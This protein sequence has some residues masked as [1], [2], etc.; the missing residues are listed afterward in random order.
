MKKIIIIVFVFIFLALDWLALHDIIKGK[1]PDFNAEYVVLTIS[2]AV[3]TGIIYNFIK[4]RT[5]TA[6]K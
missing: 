5:R 2:I 3:F 6:A 4:S 1:E